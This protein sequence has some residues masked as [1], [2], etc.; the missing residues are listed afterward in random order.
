MLIDVQAASLKVPP[1][2]IDRRSAYGMGL[3]VT[4]RVR[5]PAGAAVRSPRGSS[6]SGE[7]AL[8]I[9]TIFLKPS[10]SSTSFHLVRD[11]GARP[12]SLPL[13]TDPGQPEA[14]PRLGDGLKLYAFF[15]VLQA[16]LRCGS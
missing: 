14:K 12:A 13:G 15:K 10:I 3:L 16:V 9:S 11:A 7:E 2:L 1:L 6:F 8:Q 4:L 5:S